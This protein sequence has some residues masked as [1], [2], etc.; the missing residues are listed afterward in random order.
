VEVDCDSC[1]ARFSKRKEWDGERQHHMMTAERQPFCVA[2][3]F[4]KFVRA[5]CFLARLFA[6]NNRQVTLLTTIII[7]S[8]LLL[9]PMLLS[10]VSA[11]NFGR[12]KRTIYTPTAKKMLVPHPTWQNSLFFGQ[13]HQNHHDDVRRSAAD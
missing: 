5:M 11:T 7:M 4:H 10:A 2:R 8:S 13:A 12:C 6:A 3:S 1:L 9:R